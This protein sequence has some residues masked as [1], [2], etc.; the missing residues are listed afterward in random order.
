MRLFKQ[1]SGAT[2]SLT[3]TVV[4]SWLV[5]W[6]SAYVGRELDAVGLPDPGEPFWDGVGHVTYMVPLG[7]FVNCPAPAMM[8]N[9]LPARRARVSFF[10][11][12]SAVPPKRPESQEW[13]GQRSA[14][15]ALEA[16]VRGA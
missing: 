5:E 10:F 11:W 12:W 7:V 14:S 9:P 8:M 13:K 2:T 1:I 6:L 4:F 15:C 3:V 16:D